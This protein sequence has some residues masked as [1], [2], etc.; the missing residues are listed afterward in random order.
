MT[1]EHVPEPIDLGKESRRS[2][3]AARRRRARRRGLAASLAVLVLI[4]AVVAG[5]FGWYH[6]QLSAAGGSHAPT[7]VTVPSGASTAQIGKVLASHD[8]IRNATA[9]AWHVRFSGNGPFEAGRYRFRLHSSVDDAI[10]VL[11]AGP[12]APEIVKVTIPEGYRIDQI[13]PRIHARVPRFSEAEIRAAL[14]G[15]K[16]AAPLLPAGSN[17]YEGLLFPATYE[18]T[19]KTSVVDLLQQ[20]ADALSDR[21]ATLGIDAG[22]AKLSL[23]PYQLVIVASLVQAEAGNP[24]EAPKIA[25]V[26]YNRLSHGQPLG[27]DATSRYLSIIS[28]D[29]VD[30]ESNSP[31]NTRRNTGLPPTPIGAPGDVALNAALHPAD[32][33]WLWYVRDVH[34]DAQGRPQHVFTDSAEAFAEAK[35][36]CHDAGLG[37]GA[38]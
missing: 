9:F 27:I 23:S 29:A 7:L 19:E 14:N 8:V 11:A 33:D 20:M 38:Q 10:T 12:L 26:I 30:F 32:G 31:Y 22:A 16:V 6:A 25:R 21:Q 13:V 3:A 34:N 37:C 1:D 28:G 24:D 15:R 2:R 36:A 17:N 18:V 4:A 35:R 5:S